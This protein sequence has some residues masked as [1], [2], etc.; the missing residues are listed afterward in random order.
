[1]KPTGLRLTIAR[2]YTPAGRL[3]QRDYR[4][5]SKAEEGGIF[6]DVEVV[7]KANEEYKVFKPYTDIV[8]TPGKPLPKIEFTEKDPVLDK[9]VE[10]LTGKLDLE[11]A[12]ADTQKAREE[13]R[14]KKAGASADEPE[15]KTDK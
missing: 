1:M 4:D 9:A 10:I 13:R 12:K 15:E 3:I 7:V 11:T 8:Y 6:P 14:A 5:K 2:Y